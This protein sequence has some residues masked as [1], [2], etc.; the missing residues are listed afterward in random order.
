MTY[1]YGTDELRCAGF[2]WDRV[3]SFHNIP[4]G[5]DLVLCWKVLTTQAP[6]FYC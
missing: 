4:M 6:F 5:L 2:D 3:I 1:Y